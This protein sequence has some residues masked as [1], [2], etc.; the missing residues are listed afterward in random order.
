MSARAPHTVVQTVTRRIMPRTYG[1]SG[2]A[3]VV[4]GA[5][6]HDRHAGAHHQS[7][8][9]EADWKEIHGALGGS[10]QPLAVEREARK[11]AAA[12]EYA[13]A[14]GRNWATQV[15]AALVEG[16]ETVG[17][18]HEIKLAFGP[19]AR[20]ADRVVVGSAGANRAAKAA[21]GRSPDEAPGGADAYGGQRRGHR[22]HK[23]PPQVP[24]PRATRIGRVTHS[25]P[26]VVRVRSAA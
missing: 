23:A 14:R 21:C 12:L 16:Q 25:G 26:I 24:A 11:V 3:W 13:V 8:A 10:G 1:W 18:P 19:M 22:R 2:L 6:P 7:L 4:G 15:R 9:A 17:Q 5:L 20:L